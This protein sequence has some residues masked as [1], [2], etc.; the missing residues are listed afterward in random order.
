MKTTELFNIKFW[1]RGA[2]SLV[3]VP[4]SVPFF[5]PFSV[6]L[7]FWLASVTDELEI[8]TLTNELA[9]VGV[10]AEGLGTTCL[11]LVFVTGAEQLTP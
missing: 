1:K 9:A 2:Y 10:M 5:E 8:L 7:E 11:T 3:S 6:L 4:F